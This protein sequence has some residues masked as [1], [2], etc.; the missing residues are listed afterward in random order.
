MQLVRLGEPEFPSAAN[1]KMLP[2]V[3]TAQ[4]EAGRWAA[5]RQL[6]GE[7]REFYKRLPKQI[8]DAA[9]TKDAGQA[10]RAR[11]LLP[12]VDARDVI[13]DAGSGS[14]RLEEQVSWMVLP[15]IAIPA[16]VRP[17][18]V[19]VID[20]TKVELKGDGTWEAVPV[21]VVSTPGGR[22][23]LRLQY[24]AGAVEI[25]DREGKLKVRLNAAEEVLLDPKG[26]GR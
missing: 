21:R 2:G 9:L 26:S 11:R 12:L 16:P 18:L 8:H 15:R 5:Y 7:L 13:A 20:K 23:L 3:R 1:P 22:V 25:R 19:V 24:N 14:A 4:E 10:R 6:G 17:P